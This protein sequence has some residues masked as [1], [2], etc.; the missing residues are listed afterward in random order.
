MKGIAKYAMEPRGYQHCGNRDI[1]QTIQFTY[2]KIYISSNK[3]NVQK[4]IS[5]CL[6][7]FKISKSILYLLRN[8]NRDKYNKVQRHV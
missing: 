6:Q 1:V 5:C 8:F 4:T 3:R 7:E 2:I